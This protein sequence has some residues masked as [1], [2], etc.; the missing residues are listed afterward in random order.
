MTV[1]ETETIAQQDYEAALARV[2]AY[3]EQLERADTQADQNS[4]DRA[5][6]LAG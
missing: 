5:A 1:T 4:L 6:D 3:R 2:A